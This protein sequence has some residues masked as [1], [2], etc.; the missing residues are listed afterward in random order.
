M[1]YNKN[2]E[3]IAELP[4][5]WSAGTYCKTL[6]IMSNDRG[7]VILASEE[8]DI[9]TYQDIYTGVLLNKEDVKTLV[10][11]LQKELLDA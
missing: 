10:E 9:E 7:W 4:L 8:E 2:M 5:C 11:I 6:K 1:R 3:K